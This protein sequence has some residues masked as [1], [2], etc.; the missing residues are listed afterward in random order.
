[1]AGVFFTINSGQIATGTAAKTILQ[2]VAAANQRVLVHEANIAFEGVTATDAPIQVDLIQQSTA[3]SGSS[4][5]TPVK[6]DLGDDETL[7]TTAIKGCTSEPTTTSI[8]R[9][10]LV[11]PQGGS[12]HWIFDPPVPVKGGTRLGIVV[13]AAVSI[14]CLADMR[15]EE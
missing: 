3:G 15:L 2:A 5:V 14:D 12:K 10:T 6:E 7:Q 4:P 13:T 8:L 9:S 11:H 1:M